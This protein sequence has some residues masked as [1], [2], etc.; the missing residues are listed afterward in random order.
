VSRLAETGQDSSRAINFG[1]HFGS[2]AAIERGT[3]EP[4]A[5]AESPPLFHHFD[6]TR[7]ARLSFYFVQAAGPPGAVRCERRRQ[8][9]GDRSDPSGSKAQGVFRT[10]RASSDY[11]HRGP[12][13]STLR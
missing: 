2:S 13:Q 8:A 7:T 12:A 1:R 9:S 5:N 11:P 6:W 4:C 10:A 3:M